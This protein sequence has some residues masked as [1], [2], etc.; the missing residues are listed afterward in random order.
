MTHAVKILTP[1]H[2][3]TMAEVKQA[4]TRA[5]SRKYAFMLSSRQVD[6]TTV[7]QLRIYTT[8]LAV[9]AVGFVA[10]PPLRITQP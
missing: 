5:L 1:H 4:A 6:S 10:L 7:R 3:T 2:T 9:R 8:Q